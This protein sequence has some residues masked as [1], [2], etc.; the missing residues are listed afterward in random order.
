MTAQSS[1]SFGAFL[2]STASQVLILA[3]FYFYQREVALASAERERQMDL[4]SEALKEIDHR[5]RNN[6]QTVVAVIPTSSGVTP[7]TA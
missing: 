7:P 3:I 5:T 2:F 6:Y 1:E 4:L